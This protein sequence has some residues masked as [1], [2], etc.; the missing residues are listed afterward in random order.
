MLEAKF[1]VLESG[2]IIGFEI[3]G[4]SDYSEFGKDIVCA[5]VSS[6]AYMTVN[7]LTDVVKAKVEV[8]VEEKSG[9]MKAVIDE[10]DLLSCKDILKGFKQ[11]LLLLEE[12]YSK[13]IKVSYMEVQNNA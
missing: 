11:H 2:E 13:N 7:T 10:K 12:L 9:Y 5:A 4:H 3:L 8:F 6:A 1:F